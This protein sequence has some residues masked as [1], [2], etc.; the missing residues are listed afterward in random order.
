MASS[1][2]CKAW[3]TLPTGA[4]GPAAPG[5]GG[6]GAR[7]GVGTTTGPGPTGA[8]AAAGAEAG[9]CARLALALKTSASAL[10]ATKALRII[11]TVLLLRGRVGGGGALAR[12]FRGSW[13]R[14][15]RR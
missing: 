2:S 13:S 7:V 8:R 9:A 3:V 14:P 10:R 15:G 5:G 6:G 4:S 12:E 1:L 11:N